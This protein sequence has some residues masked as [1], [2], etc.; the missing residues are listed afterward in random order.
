MAS[1]P[2]ILESVER[3]QSTFHFQ[4]LLELKINQKYNL[5]NILQTYISKGSCLR[6]IKNC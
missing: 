1:T 6:I 3:I 4:E 2:S 5:I